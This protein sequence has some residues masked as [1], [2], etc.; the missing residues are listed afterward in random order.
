MQQVAAA[1]AQT[2]EGCLV[3]WRWQPRN[4]FDNAQNTRTL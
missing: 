3:G 1:A 2:V 4:A